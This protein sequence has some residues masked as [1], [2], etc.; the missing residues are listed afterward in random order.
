MLEGSGAA[1]FDALIRM[2]PGWPTT[3]SNS[4]GNCCCEWA[5][6]RGGISQNRRWGH[7]MTARRAA[8]AL[9]GSMTRSKIC[10][11]QHPLSVVPAGVART[12]AVL[13]QNARYPNG[14][15]RC[16]PIGGVDRR[17]PTTAGA[18]GRAVP[19]R[20]LCAIPPLSSVTDCTDGRPFGH[21]P[22]G[23][24]ASSVTRHTGQQHC[25]SS[26]SALGDAGDS[27]AARIARKVAP[28]PSSRAV[29]AR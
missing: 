14:H 25:A 13:V 11:H 9:P 4:L 17:G 18:Q 12:S 20:V 19:R 6:T 8:L 10:Y 22:G 5:S 7:L 24:R 27:R 2:P 15:N 16:R 28:A 26:G 29:V 23:V 3:T 21:F 1:P